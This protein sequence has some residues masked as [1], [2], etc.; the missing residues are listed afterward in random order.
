MSFL[1]DKQAVLVGA[2]RK[3]GAQR[4]LIT[5][6]SGSRGGTIWFYEDIINNL[7]ISSDPLLSSLRKEW[8]SSRTKALEE[9]AKLL[10][11]PED[12]DKIQPYNEESDESVVSDDDGE[13]AAGFM[14][15]R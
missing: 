7:L 13:V 15:M 9:E 1:V 5:V 2:M 12:G 3:Q 10:L 11:C 14:D 6:G 8:Q 4:S